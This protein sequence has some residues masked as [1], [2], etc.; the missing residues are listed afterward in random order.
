[1]IYDASSYVAF[2]DFG[3]KYRY[4]KDQLSWAVLGIAGMF[5]V[6]LFDYK[7]ILQSRITD[8]YRFDFIA[9][10]WFLFRDSVLICSARGDGLI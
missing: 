9:S 2:R 8:S 6:S 3:D 7:K 10:Y 1:M 4:I 5:I